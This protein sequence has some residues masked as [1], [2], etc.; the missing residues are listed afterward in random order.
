MEKKK[1]SNRTNFARD[2]KCRNDLIYSQMQE[3]NLNSLVCDGL[4]LD[5]TIVIR[6]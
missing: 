2:K 3:N 5:Y 6:E 1:K 4:V